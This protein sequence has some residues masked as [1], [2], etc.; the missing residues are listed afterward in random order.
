MMKTND[1]RYD[2]NGN[3]KQTVKFWQICEIKQDGLGGTFFFII[4]PTDALISKIYFG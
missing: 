4:K 2:N 1:R 3:N